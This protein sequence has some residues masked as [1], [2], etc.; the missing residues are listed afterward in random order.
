MSPSLI[1]ICSHGLEG[2]NLIHWYRG[3]RRDASCGLCTAWSQAF[4]PVVIGPIMQLATNSCDPYS[5]SVHFGSF[6]ASGA[7]IIAIKHRRSL[8]AQLLNK[9][10]LVS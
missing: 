1:S 7:V 4:S 2:V 8:M 10:L 6:D 9:R 3:L 5:K